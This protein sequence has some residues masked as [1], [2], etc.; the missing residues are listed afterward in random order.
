MLG[1]RNVALL[2]SNF[3]FAAVCA[4][5]FFYPGWELVLYPACGIIFL[6]NDFRREDEI[7]VI[8]V[9]L[10][11]AAALLLMTRATDPGV[12]VGLAIEVVGV[13]ALSFGL[14]L[15]RGQ[16]ASEEGRVLSKVDEIEAQTRD[17][18]R[19]LRFY[20][21]YEGTAVAQIRLRRDLTQ[22][23][24]SLGTTMDPHE[25]Q[26]RLMK[27]L[28]GR[29][30]GSRVKILPGMPQDPIVNWAAKTHAPV[31]VKDMDLEMRFGPR[32][33]GHGFRSALVVPL[34]VMKKPYGF[35]A[36]KAEKTG[37]YTNDDLR[38]VDLFAT[39]ASLTLENIHLYEEVHSLAT[40]DGLT[41]LFTQRAFRMRLKE[42]ML[43]AGRSQMPMGLIM[44]DIDFFKRYNDTYGHQAGDELLRAVARIL[45]NQTRPVD[46]VAR[47]GGE[48]FAVILPNTVHGRAVDLANRMRDAVASEPFVFQGQRTRVTMSFGVSSFPSDATSLSQ[49]VRVADER[50][51]N[52][53]SQ[54]RDQV[55]G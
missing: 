29:Y 44:G 38:T 30:K 31:L 35:V 12:R 53:K 48:E 49:L 32:S 22:A 6:W 28:E 33:T 10:A 39:L 41:Q 46:C 23:A 8:F 25:V 43:R 21:T 27:I 5:L 47:Y 42:E 19:E 17:S 16:L 54:G 13:W 40:H 3:I 51:Y 20:N 14:G 55:T 50:L 15:H 18:Q 24:K 9:F 37:A 52:S 11:T 36:L 4:A 2:G 26:V 1:R 34:S 7:H 45:V